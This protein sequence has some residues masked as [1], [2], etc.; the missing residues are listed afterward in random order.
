MVD[1]GTMYNTM[2]VEI[3]VGAVLIIESRG[4]PGCCYSLWLFIHLLVHVAIALRRSTSAPSKT[5]KNQ[6]DYAGDQQSSQYGADDDSGL[7]SCRETM[8]RMTR[9]KGVCERS[10]SRRSVLVR[11]REV[12]LHLGGG[13]LVP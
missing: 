9:K 6:D 7:G 10:T 4:H 2:I 11:G 5:Q 1:D 13:V 8:T 3:M 12:A